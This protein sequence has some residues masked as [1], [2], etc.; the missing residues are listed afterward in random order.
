[1]LTCTYHQASEFFTQSTKH[2]GFKHANKGYK[3]EGMNGWDDYDPGK[4]S[5]LEPI[6]FAAQLKW[7]S[8]RT[9]G[10]FH[11]I[12]QVLPCPHEWAWRGVAFPRLDRR[13]HSWLSLI[14]E[15]SKNVELPTCQHITTYHQP[16]LWRAELTWKRWIR[17]RWMFRASPLD[18]LPKD[19]TIFH[20]LPSSK[21]T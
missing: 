12:C 8:S 21:P 17:W 11:G 16:R 13:L 7:A 2:E 20:G 14:L 18:L 19:G 15:Y 9:T 10:I 3:P 5:P 1:M 4:E 6:G